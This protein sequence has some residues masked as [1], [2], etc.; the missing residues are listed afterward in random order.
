MAISSPVPFPVLAPPGLL[1]A[2]PLLTPCDVT[3]VIKYLLFPRLTNMESR[4]VVAKGEG[5]EDAN[6]YI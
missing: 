4:L 1:R 3:F 6:C 5:E 2:W